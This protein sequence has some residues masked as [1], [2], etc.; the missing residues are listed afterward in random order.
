[1][2]KLEAAPDYMR[3]VRQRWPKKLAELGAHMRR[4]RGMESHVL[5]NGAWVRH[6][7]EENGLLKV[8]IFRRGALQ[9]EK[10]RE[11]WY[12]EVRTFQKHLNAG[13]WGVL[14]SENENGP[15]VVL[16]ESARLL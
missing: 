2:K 4:A 16:L 14:T 6:E 11:A 12:R 3:Y 13:D 5:R 9:D 1:M 8:T 15:M 10:Q 7:R